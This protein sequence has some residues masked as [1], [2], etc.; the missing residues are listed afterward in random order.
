MDLE[1]S[2]EALPILQRMKP[3]ISGFELLQGSMDDVFLNV[4]GK[5]LGQNENQEVAG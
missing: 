4:T 5:T 1:S 3:D 2:L